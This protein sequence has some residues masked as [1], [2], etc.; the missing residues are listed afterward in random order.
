MAQQLC[1]FV[2]MQRE[3]NHFTLRIVAGNLSR[4]QTLAGS[5]TAG[6]GHP[7]PAGGDPG[8]AR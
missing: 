8:P 3:P 6:S 5:V 1:S 4:P 7:L 2:G